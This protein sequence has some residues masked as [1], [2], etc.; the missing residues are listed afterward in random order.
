MNPEP[1]PVPASHKVPAELWL[2]IL[3]LVPSTA[4][5]H[6]VSVT[7]KKLH[8][9]SVRALHR[10]LS[11][12][13]PQHIARS[14][15]IWDNYNGMDA[16]VRSLELGVSSIDRAVGFD[17]VGLNGEPEPAL[18]GRRR[19]GTLADTINYY[20][21][22]ERAGGFASRELYEAMFAR[23][24]T[25]TNLSS[26]T[27]TNMLVYDLHFELIHR[28]PT[29]RHLH[30]E[31]CVFQPVP[32]GQVLNHADLP[33]T[34]LT[35]VNLRRI[36]LTRDPPQYDE[37][38]TQVLTLCL[39]RNL[40]TLTVDSSADVFRRVFGAWDAQQRGWTIPA[41]LTHVY[42]V[43]RRFFEGDVHTSYRGESNF[44]EA[45]L[46]HFAV[47]AHELR[48]LWTLAFAPANMTIAHEALPPHLERFAAPV[49]TAV[50]MTGVRALE[51]LGIF[52]CGLV[53]RE[54]INALES[55]AANSSNLKML[56][57]EL[58]GWD[59]EVISAVTDLFKGLRRLKIVYEGPEGPTEDFLVMLAPEFLSKLPHLHTLE[60]Y[61][62][63]GQKGP[64]PHY[65]AFLHDASFESLEEELCNIVIPYNRY[66]PELRRVQ[67]CSGYV[68]TRTCAG[69]RWE[70]ERI[71][72]LPERDDL[73]Y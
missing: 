55:V 12:T 36:V 28:L 30:L 15:P 46:Y 34:E 43:R 20:K 54:A 71:R 24:H 59:E 35:M 9:L 17:M 66:C 8:E 67:L 21:I 70:V 6:S 62:H 53:G 13:R 7:C 1:P 37:D 16:A 52:K 68:V 22:H 5:L 60:L 44:P 40:R 29:L 14:L 63:P 2:D 18:S 3:D 58:K 65:P 11:W 23:I 50:A 61:P 27:F 72:R 10:G 42:V 31:L 69:G 51:A 48:T 47:Q 57:L 49:E 33:I 56:M 39:A 45:H 26:L 4:D 32:G 41:H 73:S 19:I 25:F 64:K 38:I